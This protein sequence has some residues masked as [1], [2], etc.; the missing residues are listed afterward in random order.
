MASIK[1]TSK[2]G[3]FYVRASFG[4]G[5]SQRRISATLTGTTRTIEKL[6]AE[7]EATER[8]QWER[9]QLDE[10]ELD[11][12]AGATLSSVWA[13]LIREK[14]PSWSP[15]HLERQKVIAHDCDLRDIGDGRVLGESPVGELARAD[16]AEYL[17]RYAAE[18]IA[19]GV[20]PTRRSIEARLKAIRSAVNYAIDTGRL[21]GDPTRKM[22]IP[23]GRFVEER[24]LP[25]LVELE[26]TL[27]KA[28]VRLGPSKR[29]LDRG[30]RAVFLPALVSV[31]IW[32]GM[33]REE[34]LGLRFRDVTVLEDGWSIV[35]VR[36]A[37]TAAP[38]DQGGYRI[39]PTKND[40][41]REL[42]LAPAATQAIGRRRLA[43][44][45]ELAENDVQGVDVGDAFVFSA[46]FGQHP[47]RPSSVWS[48]WLALRDV[49]PELERVTFKDLRTSHSRKVN[50]AV[51]HRGT[52]AAHMGHG[53]D[54]NRKH[55]D[56]RA[57]G[58]LETV[59]DAI[60]GLLD[61]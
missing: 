24:D 10:P 59:R 40:Q 42:P 55:Y 33:R 18:P 45:L 1:A 22:A 36:R 52:V 49:E 32:S 17:N 51:G 2:R 58:D 27:R 26:A 23:K 19:G 53:E 5:K 7:W 16:V 44:E 21:F 9:D 48:W 47:L 4:S 57:P 15:A 25:D 54:V 37:V 30:D 6:A 35:K 50:R 61:D 43:L 14:A 12:P 41:H 13:E 11:E 46:S 38:A 20:L 28:C 34:I 31:A 29:Y 8:A 60:A 56:G 39:G 3:R